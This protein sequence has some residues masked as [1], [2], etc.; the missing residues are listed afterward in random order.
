MLREG[1]PV[2]FTGFEVAG[3]RSL[4]DVTVPLGPLTVVVGANGSGKSNLLRGLALLRAAA[5]AR[6]AQELV[7]EGGLPAVAFAT[8]HRGPGRP[9]LRLRIAAALGGTVTERQRVERVAG[10]TTLR[11]A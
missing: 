7:R 1:G 3:Y 11:P 6:L 5:R 4:V 2:R 10:A 8:T 9:P